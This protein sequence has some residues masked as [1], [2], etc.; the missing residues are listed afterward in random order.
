MGAAD[1][2]ALIA[3]VSLALTVVLT[4]GS[5][6]WTLSRMLSK[7]RA[8]IAKD[9]GALR[10]TVNSRVA[11]LTQTMAD[12]ETDDERRFGQV[13]HDIDAAGDLIRHEFGETASAIREHLRGIEKEMGERRLETERL[14]QERHSEMDKRVRDLEIGA[15]RRQP[16]G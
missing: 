15:A 7:H 14:I 12:H 4:V 13:R 5:V 3:A 2:S 6:T 16:R 11:E 10:E 8:G 9:I 1:I